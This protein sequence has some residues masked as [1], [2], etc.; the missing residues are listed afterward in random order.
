MSSVE[1]SVADDAHQQEGATLFRLSVLR[2]LGTVAL[3]A[4]CGSLL[5]AMT[6]VVHEDAK[7]TASDAAEVS[8]AFSAWKIVSAANIPDCMA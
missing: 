6:P 5:A 7:L 4:V 2:K 3:V 8:F 1:P